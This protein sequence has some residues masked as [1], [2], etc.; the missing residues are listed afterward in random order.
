MSIEWA[1]GQWFQTPGHKRHKCHRRRGRDAFYAG[2]SNT[3]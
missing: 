3:G 1:N 2:Q